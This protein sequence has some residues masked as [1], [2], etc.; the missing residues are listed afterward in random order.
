[1]LWEVEI[2]PKLHDPETERVRQELALLTHGK[3]TEPGIDLSSRGYLLQE[4][5]QV[6]GR[7]ATTVTPSSRLG[8]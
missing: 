1:M 8:P 2:S 5:R 7:T 4:L 6:N 3:A